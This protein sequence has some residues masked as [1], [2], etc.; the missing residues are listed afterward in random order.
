MKYYK[1]SMNPGEVSPGPAKDSMGMDMVPVY[2]D[3]A[4]AAESSAI[5]ID[6]VTMQNMDLRTGLVTRGPLRRLMRTVG[7]IDY[8]ETALAEVTT[9]FRGLDREAVC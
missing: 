8:D 4:A 5:T 1:S 6:P 7:V 2:E 3:E 9:K